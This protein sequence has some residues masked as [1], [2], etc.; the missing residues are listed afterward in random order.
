[1]EDRDSDLICES[2]AFYVDGIP[3]HVRDLC[4]FHHM[5]SSSVEDETTMSSDDEMYIPVTKMTIQLMLT[6]TN[7]V[8]VMTMEVNRL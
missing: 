8:T 2:Q 3:C 1:M 7:R 6:L 5:V 4:S